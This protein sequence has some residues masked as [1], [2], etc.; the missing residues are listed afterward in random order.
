M[1]IADTFARDDRPK[2]V[3]EPRVGIVPVTGPGPVGSGRISVTAT[4]RKIQEDARTIS[5]D[6]RGMAAIQLAAPQP[7]DLSRETT[8]ELSLVVEYRLDTPPTA[9]VALALGGAA[10]PI[11]GNLKGSTPGE[12]T[13]LT[14]PLKCFAARGADMSKI[15]TPFAIETM[16][17]LALTISD[18]RITSVPGPQDVCGQP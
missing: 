10:V 15:A 12:W 2:A 16:G 13:M 3:A 7:I 8:G 17:R 18:I 4:D 9:P 5:W 6:G 11:A 1:P 14:M